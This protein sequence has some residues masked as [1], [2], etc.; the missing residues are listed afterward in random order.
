MLLLYAAWVLGETP[1]LW[2]V[3]GAMRRGS[4]PHEDSNPSD[5]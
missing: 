5:Y 3:K 1:K 4:Q 2:I